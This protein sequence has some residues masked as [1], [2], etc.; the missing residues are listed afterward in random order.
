M[1]LRVEKHVSGEQDAEFQSVEW[2]K[3]EDY[4]RGRLQ[5]KLTDR[6]LV[7]LAEGPMLQLKFFPS[8]NIM[9]PNGELCF[10]P[11]LRQAVQNQLTIS[12]KKQ[13]ASA[14]FVMGW[15]LKLDSVTGP[16]NRSKAFEHFQEAV[17][18]RPQDFLLRKAIALEYHTAGKESLSLETLNVAKN[19]AAVDSFDRFEV[20]RNRSMA[21]SRL[22]RVH[23]AKASCIRALLDAERLKDVDEFKQRMNSLEKSRLIQMEWSNFGFSATTNTKRC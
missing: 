16:I 6:D 17:R 14:H 18:L 22:G 9:G 3:L 13:Q 20:E 2:T 23:E 21:L 19:L 15:L 11:K 10:Y 5:T 7:A 12:N 1:W 8:S 4:E